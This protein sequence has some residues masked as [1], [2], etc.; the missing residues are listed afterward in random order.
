MQNLIYCVVLP[1]VSS[2]SAA[3][4]ASGKEYAFVLEKKWG[5]GE[6]NWRLHGGFSV[7]ASLLSCG[8]G[9]TRGTPVQ[10]KDDFFSFRC[11]HKF[12][13][14]FLL[15]KSFCYIFFLSYQFI[16]KCYVVKAH[17]VKRWK[18]NMQ[19]HNVCEGK[20]GAFQDLCSAVTVALN[21]FS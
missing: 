11:Y 21:W 8:H 20:V 13:P 12:L 7:S 3:S 2:L 1:L 4:F 16:A 14:S 6:R 19:P 15:F 9:V 10:T 18:L 17:A 5:K